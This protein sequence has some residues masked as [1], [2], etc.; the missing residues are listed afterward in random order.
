VSAVATERATGVATVVV[1]PKTRL[2]DALL[3]RL[4]SD[5]TYAVARDERDRADLASCGATVV[6]GGSAGPLLGDGGPRPLRI[7][8]CA[9]GPV[10]PETAQPDLDAA[11]VERDLDVVA[12]LLGE[13]DGREVHVVLVSTII[14]LG[15]GTDRSYYA[16]WKNVVEGRLADLVD[17]HPG[18]SLSVLYPGRLMAAQDRRRPWH[19]SHTTFERLASLMQDVSEGPG[20]SRIVGLDARAWLVARSASL[21]VTSLSGSRGTRRRRGAVGAETTGRDAD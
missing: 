17:A 4:G 7:H 15:P 12:R 6:G 1:G 5:S 10:H 2:G 11:Y 8:V 3:A 19:R 18:A 14:A 16:G 20:R 21:L 9:L 13:A